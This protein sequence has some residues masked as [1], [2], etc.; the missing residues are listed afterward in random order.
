MLVLLR[1]SC[2]YGRI[3]IADKGALTPDLRIPTKLLR[4]DRGTTGPARQVVSLMLG[5]LFKMSKAILLELM[6][7]SCGNGILTHILLSEGYIGEGFDLR[8]RASWSHYPQETQR[9]LHVQPFNPF[10]SHP[11]LRPLTFLI[12]NH[13]DELTPWIPVMSALL[14]ASGYLSIPCCPWDFDARFERGKAGGF[15]VPQFEPKSKEHEAFVDGLILGAEGQ[16]G[17]SYSKY[18]IWLAY[19]S[20]ACGWKVECEM[21]RIPSTRNWAIVGRL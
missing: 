8:A 9:H 16:G 13:A 12:G 5:R 14:P 4:K 7:K 15:Q 20:Q 1:F 17:T 11:Q 21:L 18:R 3:P 6:H 10:E 2:C 19:L